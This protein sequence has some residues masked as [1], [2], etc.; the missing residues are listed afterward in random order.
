MDIHLQFV[1]QWTDPETQTMWAITNYQ[2]VWV[3]KKTEWAQPRQIDPNFNKHCKKACVGDRWVDRKGIKFAVNAFGQ[4]VTH[5][6]M[7]P[8]SIR[9]TTQKNLHA[10]ALVLKNSFHLPVIFYF[11]IIYNFV[12][13]FDSGCPYYRNKAMFSFKPAKN[14]DGIRTDNRVLLLRSAAKTGELYSIDLKKIYQFRPVTRKI[15]EVNIEKREFQEVKISKIQRKILEHVES[16]HGTI[17]S[18]YGGP[19]DK[20]ESG[21]PSEKSD[22]GDPS[23]KSDSGGPSEKSDSGDPSEKSDSG[24]PLDKSDSDESSKS[25]TVIDNISYLFSNGKITRKLPGSNKYERFKIKNINVLNWITR[26]NIP[27]NRAQVLYQG[28][29]YLYNKDTYFSWNPVLSRW[30]KS[31]DIPYDAQITLLLAPNGDS[32]QQNDCD[33]LVL[34]KNMGSTCYIDSLLVALLAQPTS[35]IKEYILEKK[36]TEL[37]TNTCYGDNYTEKRNKVRNIQD[38]LVN[39]HR[40]IHTQENI[41]DNQKNPSA[42][43]KCDGFVSMLNSCDYGIKSNVDVNDMGDPA[44][45][46]NRIGD[47]F[48]I[49]TMGISQVNVLYD[50]VL[51]E[52]P[53]SEKGVLIKENNS[54]PVVSVLPF[55]ISKLNGLKDNSEQRDLRRFLKPYDMNEIFTEDNY[56][57]VGVYKY[58]RKTLEVTPIDKL[59]RPFLIIDVQRGVEEKMTDLRLKLMKTRKEYK[60]YNKNNPLFPKTVP[61]MPW[62]EKVLSHERVSFPERMTV[63]DHALRCQALV[64]HSL[65]NHYIAYFLCGVSWYYYNDSEDK[66]LLK[67]GDFEAMYG[68]KH[69]TWTPSES[70]KLI[71]YGEDPNGKDGSPDVTVGAKDNFLDDSISNRNLDTNKQY[72]TVGSIPRSYVKVSTFSDVQGKYTKTGKL[73]KVTKRG[74][75]FKSMQNKDGLVWYQRVRKN[76][77][78]VQ[79]KK[80]ISNLLKEFK[81]SKL[82]K[83]LRKYNPNKDDLHHIEDFWVDNTD[84]KTYIVENHKTHGDYYQ[85]VRKPTNEKVREYVRLTCKKL[86]RAHNKKTRLSKEYQKSTPPP[87]E[88]VEPDTFQAKLGKSIDSNKIIG[89]FI[90]QS[91]NFGVIKTGGLYKKID[92]KW[93]EVTNKNTKDSVLSQ[94]N[95]I[96]EGHY[97][98]RPLDKC[99]FDIMDIEDETYAFAKHTNGISVYR[100]LG[101]ESWIPV[102][103]SY[104][105]E[106]T[107][108]THVLD[109]M[110]AEEFVCPKLSKNAQLIDCVDNGKTRHFVVREKNIYNVM[111]ILKYK[112]I[113]LD[114][115]P[116]PAQDKLGMSER[117][118]KILEDPQIDDTLR[119]FHD[120]Q[121]ELLG[122]IRSGVN[123][124]LNH[125]LDTTLAE[126]ANDAPPQ[127][128]LQVTVEFWM[129]NIIKQYTEGD[130]KGYT[131]NYGDLFLL[132]PVVQKTFEVLQEKTGHTYSFDP[133]VFANDALVE[134]EKLTA[135]M[136]F[137]RNNYPTTEELAEQKA[138]VIKGLNHQF[139]Y[140][141]VG[142]DKEMNDVYKLTPFESKMRE[143]TGDTSILTVDFPIK[144]ISLKPTYHDVIDAR[145]NF[146]FDLMVNDVCDTSIKN[147]NICTKSIIELKGRLTTQIPKLF[148]IR[149]AD[150][151]ML[152]AALE[153]FQNGVMMF[154]ALQYKYKKTWWKFTGHY[155]IISDVLETEL[156]DEYRKNFK[157]IFKLDRSPTRD[158]L[159]KIMNIELF[160]NDHIHDEREYLECKRNFETDDEIETHEKNNKGAND[161]PHLEIEKNHRKTVFNLVGEPPGEGTEKRKKH[162]K[163]V[164][165]T[166]KKKKHRKIVPNLVDRNAGD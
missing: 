117:S 90:H 104:I 112:I 34:F 85:I 8:Q 6:D 110:E 165:I 157:K 94:V 74:A 17:D 114:M 137:F 14:L 33:K 166:D 153:K 45:V 80:F 150:E 66:M 18:D 106:H 151:L 102:E 155:L 128:F 89:K 48:S 25:K 123:M 57:G 41:K 31:I 86:L 15:Y 39:L 146:L 46:F 100:K 35:V 136:R 19:S 98:T 22:S 105:K 129:D 93:V 108:L 71:I 54:L 124:E 68:H 11:T 127:K 152:D 97:S 96:L 63:K 120:E 73:Y 122:F 118:D 36:S 1:Y 16:K 126:I 37:P 109:D 44:D 23:D 9:K 101:H 50:P 21:D 75:V 24:D 160:P 4:L 116:D 125:T 43:L 147:H 83:E 49:L 156:S 72:F 131:L 144:R 40:E 51:K 64:T 143:L 99:V 139:K 81:E 56:K 145:F 65:D 52:A 141:D 38:T 28:T 79:F 62:M 87:D 30:T 149:L 148:T 67:L 78:D 162:K 130:R 154:R 20:S 27:S 121:N 12:I 82:I 61:D 107:A 134:A 76:Q 32:V 113:T 84:C 111:E 60:E 70:S 161:K 158:E 77:Y 53:A 55:M 135:V 29:Y 115:L 133:G 119:A 88:H 95:A 26:I 163:I 132:T 59:H 91:Q 5:N 140:Q 103:D 92:T 3:K 47:I 13:V 142:V 69:K 138:I 58:K 159:L 7:K 10:Y 164:P 42:Y 2:I